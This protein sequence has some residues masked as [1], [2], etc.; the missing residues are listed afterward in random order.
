MI[1]LCAVTQAG[2]ELKGVSGKGSEEEKEG[3]D[4]VEKI[5]LYWMLDI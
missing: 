3:L 4:I 5:K 2:L 1:F